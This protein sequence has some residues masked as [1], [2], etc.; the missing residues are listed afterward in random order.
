MCTCIF[1]S[2]RRYI[3]QTADSLSRDRSWN[4]NLYLHT[5]F[6]W[7]VW[8]AAEILSF[9]K[10]RPSAILSFWKLLFWSRGL[11]LNMILLPPTKLCV[12]R[13]IKRGNIAERRFSIWRPSRSLKGF[14]SPYA[15]NCASKCLLGFFCFR[16]LPT[17]YS[18]D[19][20]TDFHA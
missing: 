13:T 6:H 4:Q 14:L 17:S 10:W 18:L 5:K 20:W 2:A 16:V 12:N 19:A 11:C 9:S 3:A 15:R 1:F 7:I 8:S